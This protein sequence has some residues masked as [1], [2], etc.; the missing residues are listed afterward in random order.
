MKTRQPYIP[1]IRRFQGTVKQVGP[2]SGAEGHSAR[3]ASLFASS[4][5]GKYGFWRHPYLGVL[6][7]IFRKLGMDEQE[8]MAMLEH[9]RS[10]EVIVRL[11]TQLQSLQH[12]DNAHLSTSRETRYRLEQ[13]IKNYGHVLP[14]AAMAPAGPPVAGDETAR[15][16]NVAMGRPV[17]R[18]QQVE[19]AAAVSAVQL[20]NRKPASSA[21]EEKPA[22]EQAA[23]KSEIS[24]LRRKI[25][26]DIQRIRQAQQEGRIGEQNREAAADAAKPQPGQDAGAGSSRESAAGPGQYEPI[27][28]RR[29]E[30]ESDTDGRS[31]AGQTQP[32]LAQTGASQGEARQIG[33]QRQAAGEEAAEGWNEAPGGHTAE[34][35]QQGAVMEPSDRQAEWASGTAEQLDR[36]TQD[37]DRKRNDRAYAS[38]SDEGSNDSSND[39]NSNSS[40]ADSFDPTNT[41]VSSRPEQDEGVV[42]AESAGSS[43]S[44][45]GIQPASDKP[46]WKAAPATRAKGTI[47]WPTALEGGAAV[48]P[49]SVEPTL[50]FPWMRSVERIFRKMRSDESMEWETP[51]FGQSWIYSKIENYAGLP[52]VQRASAQLAAALAMPAGAAN[53]SPG[54]RE[55]IQFDHS[56]FSSTSFF[57]PIYRKASMDSAEESQAAPARAF[58]RAAAD[59]AA[60]ERA[61]AIEELSRAQSEVV[62]GRR[63]ARGGSAAD[64]TAAAAAALPAASGSR[65]LAG[66]SA[67]AEATAALHGAIAQR[68]AIGRF[69]QAK[70]ADY[71]QEMRQSGQ[72]APVAAQ[73]SGSGLTASGLLFRKQR[74]AGSSPGEPG[75]SGLL[76]QAQ[77]YLQNRLISGHVLAEGAQPVWQ[78]ALQEPASA[79]PR[80]FAAKLGEGPFAGSVDPV[81]LLIMRRAASAAAAD[82]PGLALAGR[83]GASQLV[84][85]QD[86]AAGDADGAWPDG[87]MVRSQA[88]APGVSAAAGSQGAGRKPGIAGL[89]QQA[90]QLTGDSAQQLRRSLSEIRVSQL[91]N[92]EIRRISEATL[93]LR[94]QDGVERNRPMSAQPSSSPTA[95]RSAAPVHQP[96][97]AAAASAVSAGS[98]PAS[99]SAAA[100]APGGAAPALPN[101]TGAAS[102]Q[103]GLA[104]AQWGSPD[105]ISVT[106]ASTAPAGQA[107]ASGSVPAGAAAGAGPASG[108]QPAGDDRA[109]DGAPQTVQ[110]PALAHPAPALPASRA[111]QPHSLT[112]QTAAIELGDQADVV[113]RSPEAAESDAR[114]EATMAQSGNL[115]DFGAPR[116]LDAADSAGDVVQEALQQHGAAESPAAGQAAFGADAG[117]SNA[118]RSA[119]G[120]LQAVADLGGADVSASQPGTAVA[121]QDDAGYGDGQEGE[122]GFPRSAAVRAFWR[123]AAF[124]A[125]PLIARRAPRFSELADDVPLARRFAAERTPSAGA[126]SGPAGPTGGASAAS[127]AAAS[128]AS[129]GAMGSAGTG[130]GAGAVG[131]SAP[132][133]PGPTSDA[134]GAPGGAGA[135]PGMAGSTGAASSSAGMAA[136]GGS[137]PHA[138]G[139]SGGQA[140]VGGPQ[141]SPAGTGGLDAAPN[142]AVISDRAAADSGTPD[143]DDRSGAMGNTPVAFA[144]APGAQ[145]GTGALAPGSGA[146]GG[147]DTPVGVSSAGDAA[148]AGRSGTSGAA[149]LAALTGTAGAALTDAVQRRARAL[150][151]AEGFGVDQSDEEAA[152][153]SSA[154]RRR[155][156]RSV[157]RNVWPEAL[158]LARQLAQRWGQSRETR[159]ISPA[160]MEFARGQ[161]EQAPGQPPVSAAAAPA[162]ASAAAGGGGNAAAVAAAGGAGSGNNSAAA[163][164]GALVPAAGSAAALAAAAERRGPAIVGVTPALL[165]VVRP[166][167]MRLAQLAAQP[168]GVRAANAPLY[169]APTLLYR[170]ERQAAS[171][172]DG[173]PAAGREAGM[174]RSWLMTDDS[175]R[176]G[177]SAERLQ[178]SIERRNEAEAR[179][180]E[181]TARPAAMAAG[182]VETPPGQAGSTIPANLSAELLADMPGYE[183]I[184]DSGSMYRSLNISKLADFTA[185]AASTAVAIMRRSLLTAVSQSGASA[186]MAAAAQVLLHSAGLSAANWTP[187]LSA[188]AAAP[189]GQPQSWWRQVDLSHAQASTEDTWSAFIQGTALG[190]A[191]RAALAKRSAPAGLPAGGV[192]EDGASGSAGASATAWRA[193]PA[194]ADTAASASGFDASA[195]PFA[196]QRAGVRAA[197]DRSHGAYALSGTG[198]H[199]AQVLARQHR[200]P[201]RVYLD[202]LDIADALAARINERAGTADGRGTAASGSSGQGAGRGLTGWSRDPVSRI[203][204]MTTANA[205]DG[206]AALSGAPGGRAL[207]AD[208]GAVTSAGASMVPPWS[209]SEAETGRAVAESATG[210]A[211]DSA[212]EVD[213][214]VGRLV[215]SALS[216]AGLPLVQRLW[217]PSTYGQPA[218][219]T[220]GGSSAAAAGPAG[221]APLRLTQRTSAVAEAA[222]LAERAA[223]R[224]R[225]LTAQ[226]AP[227]QRPSPGSAPGRA[228]GLRPQLT[229]RAAGAL[230]ISE[231]AAARWAAAS[232]MTRP[233]PAGAAPAAAALG[234]AAELTVARLGS[235]RSGPGPLAPSGGPQI[236]ALQAGAPA[237]A[238]QRRAVAGSDGAAPAAPG[239][240]AAG[241][242]MRGPAAQANAGWPQAPALGRH[243]GAGMTLLSAGAQGSPAPIAE[244]PRQMAAASMELLQTAQ[245]QHKRPVSDDDDFDDDVGVMQPLEMSWLRP[246]STEA[247]APVQTIPA[248]LP[249]PQVNIE[250]LREL[251]TQ[252]PQFD[253]NKIVDRVYREIEKKLKFERQRRG[254]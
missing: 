105:G 24:E 50:A 164:S 48:Q 123:S 192:T 229:Q 214:A 219:E 145:A 38:A 43:D 138:D 241:R 65:A 79:A 95:S 19:R 224:S 234:G 117:S 216:A 132:D 14:Q 9:P 197:A 93:Q 185:E 175:V 69:A 33:L 1:R 12:A 11:Q 72:A 29:T 66:G 244:P 108:A 2:I 251:V 213:V 167:T 60:A 195:V 206:S 73:R 87:G 111:D 23:L 198:G 122:G 103:P 238:L 71:V 170:R 247:P 94:Q 222:A 207:A 104:S 193:E 126:G 179:R 159:S 78:Q 20:T 250:Q 186:A 146:G 74:S 45:A 55:A 84:H 56:P 37:G 180:T 181:S 32:G 221:A 125:V 119:G 101:D 49:S 158:Q 137:A 172:P 76:E 13:W 89:V 171:E 252:L 143:S 136:A 98:A 97:Q 141:D 165:R 27:V 92:R 201:P 187:I 100:G 218:A 245:L 176:M 153:G 210:P 54:S 70:V 120:G 16:S 77:S 231:A 174:N 168:Q 67:F 131:A 254:M 242:N 189:A 129:T 248:E 246:A 236:G 173:T 21:A 5:M 160:A 25:S 26:Q 3:E 96:E 220:P 237:L 191:L 17:V 127:G 232:T 200:L 4:I 51:D 212:P 113:Q 42:Y 34:S 209:D 215:T 243:A 156:L 112:E 182:A 99:I 82:E 83:A 115:A 149:D 183:E 107:P 52:M 130:A 225:A 90:A 202:G 190:D 80:S 8:G 62:N 6:S 86:P 177:A 240:Y 203:W 199:L 166:S 184:S 61:A 59:R 151:G 188:G 140:A 58:I 128:T 39:K 152:A 249:P 75:S 194:E 68:Y 147:P 230:A 31:G 53:R 64:E 22:S 211:A 144:A 235:D 228:G 135:T 15:A 106:P 7:L 116:E 85:R 47:M 110:S 63:E 178:R 36:R 44:D 81:T 217:T 28:W 102:G 40:I 227:Q 239:V 155:G 148:L 46:S 142:A 150:Q 109:V 114:S 157:Q 121:W 18:S 88:V 139:S 124:A 161:R 118:D 91:T 57:T 223:Q 154:V 233:A 10:R 35:G 163:S 205:A 204:R 169:A 133:M 253:V 208:A 226:R 30:E 134:S 41:T 162:A 196:V